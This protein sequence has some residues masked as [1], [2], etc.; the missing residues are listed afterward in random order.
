[1]DHVFFCPPV[2]L[3]SDLSC[4]LLATPAEEAILFAGLLLEGNCRA[5]DE[6]VAMLLAAG[7][8]AGLSVI[9]ES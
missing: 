2:L 5:G 7:V 8:T 9:S 6:A 3:P 1:M 4:C